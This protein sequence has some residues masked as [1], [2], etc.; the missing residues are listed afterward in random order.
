[1]R[2]TLWKTE[3]NRVRVAYVNVRGL[4]IDKLQHATKWIQSGTFD[5]VFLAETWFSCESAYRSNPFFVSDSVRTP[6]KAKAARHT[7]GILALA[8]QDIVQKSNIIKTESYLSI[9]FDGATISSLYLPPSLSP[10][11]FAACLESLPVSH[12]LLGDFN[13]I[14]TSPSDKCNYLKQFA[15]QK[16]LRLVSPLEAR[17]DHIWMRA[18]STPETVMFWPRTQL[19]FATDHGLLGFTMQREDGYKMKKPKSQCRRYYLKFLQ[20]E[21]RRRELCLRY[22]SNAELISLAIQAANNELR[23]TKMEARRRWIDAIDEIWN[24]I[25]CDACENTLG[26]YSVERIKRTPDRLSERLGAAKSMVAA[27]RLWKRAQRGRQAR[28]V[29]TKEGGDVLDE[30]KSLFSDVYSSDSSHTFS[31][32]EIFFASEDDYNITLVNSITPLEL[33]KVIRRYPKTKSCGPDAMHA[34]IFDALSES[35]IFLQDFSSLLQMYAKYSCTPSSWNISNTCLLPKLEG[36]TCPV[37]ETR[38]VSLTNMARRYFESLMLRQLQSHPSFKLHSHQAGFKKGFSTISHVLL[39][40]EMCCLPPNLRHTVSVYLDL[41]KAFDRVLHQPLLRLMERRGCS[42]SLRLLIYSLMMHECR[43]KIAVN[44]QLT[45]PIRRTRGLFQGSILA[46]L[47][48]NLCMEALA[49][50]VDDLNSDRFPFFLLFADDI[51]FSSSIANIHRIHCAL[52]LCESWAS[53]FGLQFGIRKC[54]AVGAQKNEF[55]ING[56]RIPN[57]SC[58]KYL[59]IEFGPCGILWQTFIDRLTKSTHSTLAFLWVASDPTWSHA[60][61]LAL[62]K[63]F[64]LS[65][66]NY[67]LGLIAKFVSLNQECTDLGILRSFHKQCFEYIFGFA[68]PLPVLESMTNIKNLE[69]HF[70]TAR[71]CL[72]NHMHNLSSENPAKTLQNTLL[73]DYR[74]LMMF[75]K[76]SLLV[77]S[78]DDGNFSEWRKCTDQKKKE[79]SEAEP[80]SLNRYLQQEIEKKRLNRS[81]LVSYVEPK[82]RTTHGRLDLVLFVEDAFIR[83]QAISWRCNRYAIQKF[84]EACMEIVGRNHVNSCEHFQTEAEISLSSLERFKSEQSTRSRKFGVADNFTII[85]S[86]LNNQA[87]DE[88]SKCIEWMNLNWTK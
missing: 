17:L 35:E 34:K 59:G 71:A 75:S 20:D 64:V 57:L 47:L 8:T 38:P 66:M 61:R 84:C 9:T 55:T 77:A 82:S 52:R 88:F 15:I 53:D 81:K 62:I 31:D 28:V 70:I 39:A 78:F 86:L 80:I 40:H 73:S 4:S 13:C 7:G 42:S 46:P 51:R 33:R 68:R 83:K 63:T 41:T 74:I 44:G 19:P 65:K 29:A 5:I 76:R 11:S 18:G 72:A 87:W 49:M 27:V 6:K 48:F 37:T 14:I 50:K 56:E 22:E 3:D 23:D 2:P 54:G 67:G 85:D 69:D 26:S 16:H 10:T 45:D 24:T 43:S 79:G 60:V 58:Y 25:L 21:G 30:A 1:M 32:F 12:A 36:E